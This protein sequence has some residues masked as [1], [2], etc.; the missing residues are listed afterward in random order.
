MDK[1]SD[2]LGARLKRLRKK[3]NLTQEKLGN[4]IGAARNTIANY[5]S[6]NRNPSNAAIISICRETG[7]N[8]V[9]VRTGEGGDENMFTKISRKD[10]FSINLG[11]LSLTE[12]EYVENAVNAIAETDPE[13]LK[14]VAEFMKMW[15]GIDK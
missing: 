6:G 9:W 2:T 10:R 3:K 15:L 8:E 7:A 12:N 14:I 13:K 1:S 5:E 4:L 11:K